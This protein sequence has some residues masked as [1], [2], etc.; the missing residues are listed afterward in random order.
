MGVRLVIFRGLGLGFWFERKG[1]IVLWE[2]RED[3]CAYR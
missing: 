3:V 1:R 2:G